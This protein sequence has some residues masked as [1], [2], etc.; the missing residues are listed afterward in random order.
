ML[1]VPETSDQGRGRFLPRLIIGAA[2]IIWLA[3]NLF[4][5]TRYPLPHPDEAWY[6]STA[7]TFLREGHFGLPVVNNIHHFGESHSGLGRLFLLM[8]AGTFAALG[9]GY[10]QARLLG[11]LGSAFASVATYAAGKRLFSTRAGITAGLLMAFSWY[12]FTWGHLTRPEIWLAGAEMAVLILFWRLRD[13]PTFRGGLVFGFLAALPMNLHPNGLAFLLGFG[14]LCLIEFVWRERHLPALIGAGLGALAGGLLFAALHFLPDAAT[15]YQQWV[16]LGH[17]PV[18]VTPLTLLQTT[19]LWLVKQFWQAYGGL[20]ALQTAYLLAGI[21]GLV[22]W[23]RD[24][25][26]GAVLLLAAVSLLAFTF[27]KVGKGAYTSTLWLPFVSLIIAAGLEPV[28]DYLAGKLPRL[29]ELP[30]YTLLILPLLALNLAGDGW[31]AYRFR[32]TNYPRLVA[33]L[34]EVIPPNTHIMAQNIWWI[35]LAPG[36]R[37]FTTFIYLDILASDRGGQI[38]EEDV[39]AEFAELGIEY[40][41][42]EIK[43]GEIAGGFHPA[44]PVYAAYITEHCR[45]L[46]HIEVPDY[47]G[48]QEN[49][50]YDCR[51]P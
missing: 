40:V 51:R 38:S 32:E 13:A 31:L 50:V 17:S 12:T 36:K 49:I 7:Y 45:P 11:L 19:G 42:L 41:I 16:I 20:A 8:L 46:K 30:L 28:A 43:E 5:L 24:R 44:Y 6:A 18:E 10:T 21:G 47:P 26:S 29:Q 34:E 2:I 39:A 35:G 33:E 9:T 1:S 37:E 3:L 27:L 15:A 25:S 22:I 23:R 4:S 14:G 48:P